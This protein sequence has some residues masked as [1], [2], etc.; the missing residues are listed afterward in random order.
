MLQLKSGSARGVFYH[1][2]YMGNCYLHVSSLV[3]LV[4][5]IGS[6]SEMSPGW[7]F[8]GLILASW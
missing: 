2:A 6:G 1:T 4:C 3:Y 7:H 5:C 8:M